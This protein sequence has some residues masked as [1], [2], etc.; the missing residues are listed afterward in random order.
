MPIA[1]AQTPLAILGKAQNTYGGADPALTNTTSP[2][3]VNN[4]PANLS[5]TIPNPAVVPGTNGAGVTATIPNPNYE[6][7]P[8]PQA[9]ITNPDGSQQ[10][11]P[12]P[13]TDPMADKYKQ[14]LANVQ[15]GGTAPPTTSG[16]ATAAI[17]SN[18]PPPPVTPYDSTASDA[19]VADNKAHQTYID[20]FNKAR[21]SADQVTT[22]TQDYSTLSAS[23]GIP[24]LNTQLMNM[25][26]VMDGTEQDIE[27]EIAKAGGFATTSQV[28][29]MTLARNKS[30]V[31][32]YNNLLTT[33]DDMVKNLDTMIGLDKDDKAAQVKKID[34]QLN[35][36]QKQIE[37]A[38]KAVTN[39]Q[40]ALTDIQ[41]TEG[42][43]GIYNAA[44]ATGDPKAISRINATM[45][46]GFDLK[47]M[48][49]ADA[50]TRVQTDLKNKADT[51]HT[52]AE[53]N[54]ANATAG[55][56]AAETTKI[57]QDMNDSNGL[58]NP[59]KIGQPGYND[60]G[61]KYTNANASTEVTNY[62]T[63]Q[64]AFD[65]NNKIPPA[66]YNQAKASWV[67][68]VLKDTDFDS[69]FGGYRD[70][71]FNSTKNKQYN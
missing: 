65:S 63:Q 22:L 64:K 52:Q 26:N 32:N 48:A 1:N 7:P 37:F 19:M 57:K 62:W 35:F 17:T 59:A 12:A 34:D 43:D 21:S 28:Q 3:I 9:T 14:T 53:T 41:K 50:K 33:R 60:A 10:S 51:A 8:N 5:P 42:W 16:A 30:L 54:S 66:L 31:Q 4:T 46:N 44:L 45:G 69:I 2:N 25:K 55:K 11:A 38:D 18:T 24:A 58:P 6:K 15:A 56:T 20:D 13:T 70:P 36:D 61:V 49:T 27:N 71:Y 40:S 67:K 47:T 29:A 39:A 23:L 68:N